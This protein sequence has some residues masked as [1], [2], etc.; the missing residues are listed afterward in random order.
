[1]ACLHSTSFSLCEARAQRLITCLQ[2]VFIPLAFASRSTAFWASLAVRPAAQTA[3][4]GK[5]TLTP[6]AAPP[7]LAP[8]LRRILSYFGVCPGGL[9]MAVYS[10]SAAFCQGCSAITHIWP[11]DH[12]LVSG[13]RA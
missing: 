2:A 6:V 1:M 5:Q 3:F 4:K 7:P 10:F 9:T 11:D 8:P 12:V 13:R